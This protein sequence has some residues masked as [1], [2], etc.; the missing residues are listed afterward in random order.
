M[1]LGERLYNRIKFFLL[2]K[3]QMVNIEGSKSQEFDVGN[4]MPQGSVLGP[5]IL[6]IHIIDINAQV[7]SKTVRSYAGDTRL[8]KKIG[9]ENDCQG[10]QEDLEKIFDWTEGN[11]LNFNNGKI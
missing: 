6:M 11:N 2:D 5:L 3:K 10:L 7:Q 9:N 1:G 4:G 8:I